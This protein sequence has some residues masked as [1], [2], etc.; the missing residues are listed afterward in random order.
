MD[1]FRAGLTGAMIR[2]TSDYTWDDSKCTE[3]ACS[4]ID[5][6]VN[7]QTGAE[8][9]DTSGHTS[10]KQED[11]GWIAELWDE[12]QGRDDTI[13]PTQHSPQVVGNVWA[14]RV[15]PDSLCVCTNQQTLIVYL[16]K[17]PGASPNRKRGFFSPQTNFPLSSWSTHCL[18]LVGPLNIWFNTG[19]T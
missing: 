15:K 10:S 16:R 5:Q 9:A 3:R 11:L 12:P 2:M 8:P 7:T 19:W 4:N 18:F 17:Y 13:R 6:N 14:M 1:H